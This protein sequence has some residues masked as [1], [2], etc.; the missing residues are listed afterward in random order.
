MNPP[1]HARDEDRISWIHH[2]LMNPLTVIIGYAEMLSQSKGISE[3]ARGQAVHILE[4]AR[5]CARIIERYGRGPQPAKPEGETRKTAV[6]R[7]RILAVD[8]EAAILKLVS[9]VLGS[10]H[11]VLGCADADEALQQLL[12]DEFDVVFLDLNLG[13][14]VSGRELYRTLLLQQPEVASRVVFMTGGAVTDDEQD[15]LDNCGRPFLAKPF[16]FAVLR[17]LARG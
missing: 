2:A 6:A 7:R 15:F 9:E 10:E 8:D 12:V 1:A 11:H 17:E 5:E 13:Q 14:F 3:D 4:Q 16:D